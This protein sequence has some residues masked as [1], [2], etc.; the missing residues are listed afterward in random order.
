MLHSYASM[1]KA[2][3][4]LLF[5]VAP[6]KEQEMRTART[7]TTLLGHRTA[8]MPT[9]LP[10]INTNLLKQRFHRSRLPETH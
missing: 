8:L 7:Q 3:L 9:S 5:V 4:S 1:K 10:P 2:G 6:G